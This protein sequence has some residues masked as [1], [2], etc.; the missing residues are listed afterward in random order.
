MNCLLDGASVLFLFWC[1]MES[2]WKNSENKNK[3]V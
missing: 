3:D 1:F 2:C